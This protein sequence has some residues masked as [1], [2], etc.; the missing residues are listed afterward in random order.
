[1]N[2][3]TS[4]P[5]FK[6]RSMSSILLLA[7]QKNNPPFFKSNFCDKSTIVSAGSASPRK[8]SL[9]VALI[10][11]FFSPNMTWSPGPDRSRSMTPTLLCVA[12]VAAMLAVSVVLP[13]PP[14]N[15]WIAITFVNPTIPTLHHS[16]C[17][18]LHPC[19]CSIDPSRIERMLDSRS[20]RLRT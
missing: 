1:M 12:S 9:S 4:R 7:G 2:T 5:D 20:C 18:L 6:S 16:C 13:V 17:C 11:P 15:E 8:M 14:L 10:S 3:D 19:L